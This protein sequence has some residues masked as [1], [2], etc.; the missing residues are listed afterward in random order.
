LAQCVAHQGGFVIHCA[1]HAYC[2][3]FSLS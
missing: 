3:V 2:L 1:S